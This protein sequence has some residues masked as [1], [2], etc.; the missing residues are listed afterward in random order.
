MKKIL[1]AIS[2]FFIVLITVTNIPVT[3]SAAGSGYYVDSI[4]GSD[5]NNGTSTTT[6]W[7]TLTKINAITFQPGDK[8]L[9][10]A[11]G[12]WTGM[13]SPLGSG[14]STSQI[15]IDMYGTGVKP[16]IAGNG[17]TAGI[18]LN[19]QEY[20]TIQNMQVTNTAAS[21]AI[22]QGIY[23]YGKATGITHNIFLYNN[24]VY[25]VTGENRRGLSAP[26]NIYW[27]SGIYVSMPG[28]STSAN[29]YDNVD[30]EGNYVHDV[31][32]SG[33]R[34]NQFTDFVEGDVYHTNI[35]VKNNTISKTG[36]DGIIVANSTSPLVENNLVYDA[37]SNGTSA[38]TNIIAGVW[39][40]GVTNPTFQ[41][42]EVA[43]TAAFQS[44]GTAFD[45]DWGTGGTAIFQYN[46]SHGNGGGFWLDCAGINK[47]PSF[48]KTILRY[49]IS[50]DDLGYITRNGQTNTEIYN[51]VFYKSTGALNADFNSDGSQHKFWNNVFNF[52]SS[53]DWQS[54]IYV[55]NQYYPCVASTRD[56]SA[57][58]GNPK[59][60]SPAAAVDGI[61]FANNFKIQSFSPLIN[62]GIAIPGAG[63]KDFFGNTLYSGLADIGAHEYVGGTG[64]GYNAIVSGSKYKLVD[65][66]S[67]KV[68]G[69]TNSSIT[70]GATAVQWNDNGTTD[71]NWMLTL[72]SGSI[73]KLTNVNS[74]KVLGVKNAS[75][76][77]GADILQWTDNG[78]A[79][80]NWTLQPQGGG[81]YK[82]I[83][84]NSGKAL[85][86]SGGGMT[87]G[88]AA[89]QWTSGPT[90]DQVFVLVPVS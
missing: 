11:G 67:G 30:I 81:A 15:T 10:K 27:N 62:T 69:I 46:Y 20:W 2:I 59:F 51:N 22:R 80:H 50:V 55:T 6:P 18:Q 41:F 36:S 84:V 63:T 65:L 54:S 4:S 35:H 60:V 33:I 28:R 72:I 13:L 23:I 49:N 77:D 16:L 37:G 45:T 24:E 8:I 89:I 26:L 64:G 75:T 85:G 47:D 9:F 66:N 21:R 76:V 74:G 86:I 71:H 31:L 44:D 32:T 42:N 70:D 52:Q 40:C 39:C 1:A 73:Y 61:S 57:K 48:V 38:D 87:D 17:A 88:N 3:V 82:L 14:S 53:P 90:P 25:N 68:L 5:S 58:V 29:H 43:R 79:D 19:G 56:L 34:I 7:K 12:S 78:T 83:N